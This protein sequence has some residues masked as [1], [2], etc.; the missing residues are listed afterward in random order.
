MAILRKIGDKVRV[1]TTIEFV[2]ENKRL[3]EKLNEAK[4]L[5]KALLDVFVYDLADDEIDSGDIVYIERAEQFIKE[6]TDN[7]SD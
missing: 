7:V 2:I 6:E 3:R 5:V 4:E 1:P